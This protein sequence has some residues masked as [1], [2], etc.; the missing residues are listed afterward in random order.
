MKT[1]FNQLRY[2]KKNNLFIAS[3]IILSCFGIAHQLAYQTS[4]QM[5]VTPTLYCLGSCPKITENPQPNV[6][7]LP[8]G[9]VI[10]RRKPNTAT[11]NIQTNQRAIPPQSAVAEPC[12]VDE[13]ASV[14][15]FKS[16]NK[17]NG[18]FMEFLFRLLA[19]LLRLIFGGDTPINFPPPTDGPS[20]QPSS[21]PTTTPCIST[22]P[23]LGSVSPTTN[24]G[25]F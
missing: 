10:D 15:T 20:I 24:S 9:N 11:D 14:Q 18:A 2:I 6:I 12:S 5:P 16:R 1:F 8:K 4:A 22:A 21:E 25:C 13:T 17:Q 23:T 7:G 19:E 3:I